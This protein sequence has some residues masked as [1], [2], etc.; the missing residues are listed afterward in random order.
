MNFC[1]KSIN[2]LKGYKFFVPSFQRGYRWGKEQV[3]DLLYDVAE[4]TPEII[5][6][7]TGNETFYCI[8]PVVVKK[9]NDRYILIDGQQRL[10]T[11]F[12]I[13]NYK[14]LINKNTKGFITK[15]EEKQ[16]IELGY[17]D[18]PIYS[19]S[20]DSRNTSASL[21]S[22]ATAQENSSSEIDS[23]YIRNSYDRIDKF[24]KEELSKYKKGYETKFCDINDYLS[25]L[26]KNV[27]IIWYEINDD[28][29]I[30]D[31]YN[32]LNDGKI[33]L[34]ASELIKS[35]FLKKSH[36]INEKE[37]V[38]KEHLKEIIRDKQFKI[39]REWDI[40][41]QD[42][43]NDS[44]WFFLSNDKNKTSNRIDL[45]L[46]IVAKYKLNTVE[47]Y[48]SKEEENKRSR[49]TFY[50]FNKELNDSDINK[51][52]VEG[53]WHEIM[54]CY[55]LLKGWYKDHKM[56]HIVGFL[57]SLKHKNSSDTLYE[58]YKEFKDEES[59]SENKTKND[60]Q[61][62]ITKKIK[63]Y[64]GEEYNVF[65]KN[66][67][68]IR[69]LKKGDKYIKDVLLLHNIMTMLSNKTE[70]YRFPFDRFKQECWHEEHILPVTETEP[71][72]EIPAI[73]KWVNAHK[74]FYKDVSEKWEKI[75]QEYAETSERKKHFNEEIFVELL[76]TECGRLEEQ[77]RIGNI[78][79]LDSCTN[80]SYGNALFLY[81]RHEIIERD[82]RNKFIPICTRNA[83]L[84][85]YNET[86][87]AEW[88][89]IVADTYET[90][91]TEML[92]K[93][94]FENTEGNDE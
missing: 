79:L 12:L 45:I 14:N 91:I 10:T 60:F 77:D 17:F 85:Y 42:L 37:N 24:F 82:K 88:N 78:V 65:T 1:D 89:G 67:E 13:L 41:E 43:Q 58:L 9:E 3:E 33:E 76:N 70:V 92:S 38:E 11:I 59:S 29:D 4:F 56:Y 31:V 80:I 86:G 25:H 84:G 8:Q 40:I 49:A 73:D 71:P 34:S 50:Y 48:K 61:E 32:D 72:N 36:Y 28:Q 23:F 15:E 7:K 16:R 54:E 53:L 2:E 93:N 68:T 55:Y 57:L 62:Y 69:E 18:E 94:P 20:C 21:I 63:D 87:E 66:N 75:K 19:I 52:K 74:Y 44:F 30:H 5:D 39:A 27:R 47:E 81:K 6:K 83:F 22:Y 46:D 51:K 64:F 90:K 35:L 26:I